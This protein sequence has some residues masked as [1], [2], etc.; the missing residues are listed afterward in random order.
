MASNEVQGPI[1]LDTVEQERTRSQQWAE[2]TQADHDARTNPA[3]STL[4]QNVLAN[5]GVDDRGVE[6]LQ[7]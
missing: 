5:A 4:Q 3:L 7:R 6:G 2:E 1:K